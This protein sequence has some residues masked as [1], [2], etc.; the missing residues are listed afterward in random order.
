[1]SL[2]RLLSSQRLE[3]GLLGLTLA[4]SWVAPAWLG[5]DAEGVRKAWLVVHALSAGSTLLLLD[6]VVKGLPR[7]ER[8]APWSPLPWLLALIGGVALRAVDWPLF[9]DASSTAAAAVQRTTLIQ[10]SVS[11]GLPASIVLGARV[12]GKTVQ[13]ASVPLHRW[14]LV[15]TGLGLLALPRY[16]SVASFGLQLLFNL[17]CTATWL[18][19]FPNLEQRVGIGK[20]RLRVLACVLGALPFSVPGGVLDRWRSR[21]SEDL[22]WMLERT[23]QLLSMAGLW[24]LV[25]LLCV[26]IADALTWLL[27]RSRK[28]RTRM[29]ALALSC[30]VLMYLPRPEGYYYTYQESGWVANPMLAGVLE[31]FFLAVLVVV[32][33]V[34]LTRGLSQA[35]EDSVRAIGSI[36]EGSLD[37]SLDESGQGEVADV[38]RGFN[39]LV[40]LLKEAE[41]LEQI[42]AELRSRSG[43]LERALEELRRA[44]A[45]LVR[46]ERMV[47]VANLVKGMAHELNNPI[48]YVA[49]N[50]APLRRYCGFL[51]ELV[52]TLSDGKQRTPAEVRQLTQLT[53]NKDLKFV[54][55][56]LG[57]IITDVDDGAHRAQLIIRNLQQLTAAGRQTREPVD[58]PGL[59]EKA[60]SELAPRVPAGVRITTSC[61]EAVTV[62]AHAKQLHQALLQV[63]DNAL[64]AVGERGAIDVRLR[65][66]DEKAIL[67]IRDDGPGMTETVKQRALEPFFTTRP[68]G[69]GSGLGLAVVATIVRAH[70]G[71]L[72]IDSEVGN[73]TSIEL[74]LPV[75]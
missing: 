30:G 28:V 60:L 35:L 25:F 17:A 71:T 14:L 1:M 7:L 69:S 63:L 24:L 56:D 4:A 27:G 19:D 6:L 67:S 58:L 46:S 33:S 48:N 44:Q 38:A 29:F 39:Q 73:G 40:A 55:H 52:L 5:L 47:S 68:P 51:G 2:A 23:Y 54:C 37:V 66:V 61:D 64:H 49:G 75:T 34:T 41:F 53:E 36:G 15:T 74:T 12:L 62:L 11:L 65:R 59:V 57:R 72:T 22:Y 32:L 9:S 50:M 45:E 31:V 18:L 13:V 43:R 42:N 70:Q 8:W 10:T 3:I 20:W 26:S 21:A 16:L